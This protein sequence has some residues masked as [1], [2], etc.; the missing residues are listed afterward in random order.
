MN[1]KGEPMA[2]LFFCLIVKILD[3][4]DTEFGGLLPIRSKY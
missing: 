1:L 2:L 4:G 3:Y